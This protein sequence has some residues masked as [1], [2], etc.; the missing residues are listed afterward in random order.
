MRTENAGGVVWKILGGLPERLAWALEPKNAVLEERRLFSGADLRRILLPLFIEQFL[1]MLVGI[2]DTM[3]ISYA[4]DAAVSG[5]SLVNQFNTILLY[6]CSALAAGG[7][8]VV[9]QY[10]G[11][12]NREEANLAA[13]Q[14]VLASVMLSLL[15]SAFS[16]AFYRQLLNLLFGRVAAD[17][18]QA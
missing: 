18:M 13:G 17:V 3:M 2:A 16:L 15:L 14:L 4:G 7:A 6:L 12:R 10:I 8:V 11:S 1:V 9:S 5:V